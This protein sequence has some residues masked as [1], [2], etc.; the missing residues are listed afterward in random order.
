[1]I[2][3]KSA[4]WALLVAALI[5]VLSFIYQVLGIGGLISIGIGSS[6]MGLIVVGLYLIS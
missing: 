5:I 1:M 3:R 2:S 6:V 4:G